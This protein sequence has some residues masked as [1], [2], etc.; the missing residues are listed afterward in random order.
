M[1]P[2][3]DNQI[4]GQVLDLNQHNEELASLPV[5]QKE[6]LDKLIKYLNNM[7]VIIR[8]FGATDGLTEEFQD[9]IGQVV[10]QGIATFCR[11]DTVWRAMRA[12][13]YALGDIDSSI[14]EY[15]VI[16]KELY[17]LSVNE[18]LFTSS[19]LINH[20]EGRLVDLYE[21]C[22]YVTPEGEA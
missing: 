3:N 4:E 19:R 9:E 11:K 13:F 16:E 21:V 14:E 8:L 17:R 7:K 5:I 6:K 12:M 1:D 18:V 20:L 10:I 22:D 2:N 15:P